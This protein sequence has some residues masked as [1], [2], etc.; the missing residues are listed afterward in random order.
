MELRAELHRTLQGDCK[1]FDFIIGNFGG[2]LRRTTWS[3]LC[4]IKWIT[5]AA[6]LRLDGRGWGQ[7]QEQLGS[8]CRN[9]EEG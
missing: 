2:F 6:E 8:S 1:E 7:K 3:D 4:I 9:P 5:L